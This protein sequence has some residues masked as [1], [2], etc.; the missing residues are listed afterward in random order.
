M[1]S[2]TAGGDFIF[3]RICIESRKE[4]EPMTTALL[5]LNFNQAGLVSRI[6]TRCLVSPF[7]VSIARLS[8]RSTLYYIYQIKTA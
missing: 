5:F 1:L 8:V 3:D 2:V 7:M 6:Q 4:T